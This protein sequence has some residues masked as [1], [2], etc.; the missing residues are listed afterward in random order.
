[1]AST[2]GAR[3]RSQRERQHVTLEAIAEQTK[4]RSSLLEA[5]ERDDVSRWPGGVF[6]RAYVRSYAKAIGAD[7][8]AVVREFLERYPEPADEPADVVTAE[9]A[10]SGRRP[11][12]R[13]RFLIGSAMGKGPLRRV[14]P[15]VKEMPLEEEWS[16]AAP[17]LPVADAHDE[18][19]AQSTSATLDPIAPPMSAALDLSAAAALCSELA[20]A[21][22]S[23][24]LATALARAAQ[25]MGAAGLI[26]WMWDPRGGVLLPVLTHGYSSDTIAQ[27]SGVP[28]E[29]DN[30][31]AAAFRSAERHIVNGNGLDRGAVVVPLSAPGH[32]PG[33]LA[34]ELANRSERRPDVHAFAAILAAQLSGLIEC[35]PALRTATA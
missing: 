32:C 24:D 19:I 6:R 8:D 25:A 17:P 4:I 1:M 10:A 31:I 3:L 27:L 21:A 33:V 16:L 9:G 22:D 2:F 7:P 12:T 29:A 13:L 11:P 14:P 35:P 5:L 26:L 30:A 18:D 34:L 23:R 15:A 20:R 28:R